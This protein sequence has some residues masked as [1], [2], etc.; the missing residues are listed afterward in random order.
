MALTGHSG[1]PWPELGKV[2]PET[3]PLLRPH[4]LWSQPI[5]SRHPSCPL[6]ESRSQQVSPL[7]ALKAT[8]PPPRGQAYLGSSVPT[9][10]RSP[11]SPV[12]PTLQSP[13]LPGLVFPL[14]LSPLRSPLSQ[15]W[16]VQPDLSG[17]CWPS[18][19]AVPSAC[20]AKAEVSLCL[21]ALSRTTSG[22]GHWELWGCLL[23]GESGPFLLQELWW[24]GDR[25]L[26]WVRGMV[27]FPDLKY[28]SLKP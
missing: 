5:P 11:R 17:G 9:N 1:G 22:L 10:Q 13:P 6:Q 18:T 16:R 12:S 19:L 14:A 15:P 3:P 21:H 20:G 28:L 2:N 8:P 7:S 4:P 24:L 27:N 26:E 25:A 23:K